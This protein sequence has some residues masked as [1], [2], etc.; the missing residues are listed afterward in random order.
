MPSIAAT[1]ARAWSWLKDQL[2]PAP[3][4][5]LAPRPG[6]IA[7]FRR[8]KVLFW[9]TVGMSLFA[10]APMAFAT[11]LPLGDL[12]DTAWP[13]SA[14]VSAMALIPGPPTPTTW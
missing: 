11:F 1:S 8:D 6:L 4:V 10:L 3:G 5:S 13:I 7:A 9:V 14:S 2:A 12:P